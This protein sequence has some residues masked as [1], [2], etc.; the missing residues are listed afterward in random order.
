MNIS[1]IRKAK[2]SE[3]LETLLTE[4]FGDRSTPSTVLD[5]EMALRKLQHLGF[6]VDADSGTVVMN[7]IGDKEK[8]VVVMDDEDGEVK[9][10]SPNQDWYNAYSFIEAYLGLGYR[11]RPADDMEMYEK[12]PNIKPVNPILGSSLEEAR[13]KCYEETTV[14]ILNFMKYN[15]CSLMTVGEDVA[16]ILSATQVRHRSF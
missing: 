1:K 3:R 12:F 7:P 11:S 2:K 10:I 16:E 4:V 9:K 14:R 15:L 8:T 5:V 6:C 13:R